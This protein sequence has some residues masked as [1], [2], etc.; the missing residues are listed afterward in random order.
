MALAMQ[1][2][3]LLAA[4]SLAQS[5]ASSALIA[6]SAS[7]TP[8]R[9]LISPTWEDHAGVG[10]I[11]LGEPCSI[12]WA[13]FLPQGRVWMEPSV[14][15]EPA[16]YAYSAT[17][18]LDP[19][20]EDPQRQFM[21][22]TDWLHEHNVTATI[23]RLERLAV[24]P[25][26]SSSHARLFSPLQY[27]TTAFYHFHIETLPKLWMA[28][29]LRTTVPDLKLLL[30][31]SNGHG[32][33][34]PY[35]GEYLDLLG[36]SG[37]GEVVEA[38]ANTAADQCADTLYVPRAHRVH[39]TAFV[40]ASLRAVRRF[41]LSRVPNAIPGYGMPLRDPDAQR[42]VVVLSRNDTATRRWVNEE[43]CV[44][45]MRSGLPH[46]SV[47]VYPSGF[48]PLAETVRLMSSARAVVGAHGAG[49]ALLLY[50]PEHVAVVEGID[51]RH[52]GTS[53]LVAEALGSQ[54]L[55]VETGAGHDDPAMRVPVDAFLQAVSGAIRE[56]EL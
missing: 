36:F 32:S 1:M 23:Q 41:V 39:D 22:A 48:T 9:R 24:L 50:A 42:K 12:F 52:T 31:T 46:E 40:S 33:T 4:P 56:G 7:E 11:C 6:P 28:S 19:T 37:D 5:S 45:A 16:G 53:R 47:I 55:A 10:A 49:F 3:S 27:S 2:G 30:A 8:I 18:I 51:T 35:V 17:H 26:C 13:S 25:A 21:I 15:G 38:R 14:Y 43:D 20:G 29:E 44:A 54:Y 34:L